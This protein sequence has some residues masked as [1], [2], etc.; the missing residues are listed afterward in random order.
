VHVT[1]DGPTHDARSKIMYSRTF[2]CGVK[3]VVRHSLGKVMPVVLESPLKSDTWK[4]LKMAC[5]H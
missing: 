3:G 5:P 2:S 4:S 1:V